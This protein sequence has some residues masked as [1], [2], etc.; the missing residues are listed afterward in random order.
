MLSLDPFYPIVPDTA[1]LERL[2]PQGIKLVQL[3]IKD[4]STEHS[5][6]GDLARGRALQSV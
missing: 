4:I 5:Q 3:R 2:L 6:G 1:W